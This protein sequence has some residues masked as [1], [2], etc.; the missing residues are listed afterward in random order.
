[1]KAK[2]IEKR[3]VTLSL[4]VAMMSATIPMNAKAYYM[5]NDEEERY[6]NSED[7]IDNFLDLSEVDYYKFD[8]PK[9]DLKSVTASYMGTVKIDGVETGINTKNVTHSYVYDNMERIIEK[10]WKFATSSSKVVY[11]GQPGYNPLD[12]VWTETVKNRKFTYDTVGRLVR[13]DFI[14]TGSSENRSKIY[15]LGAYDYIYNEKN[16]IVEEKRFTHDT[17]D[18]VD[19][20]HTLKKFYSYDNSGKLVNT[21]KENNSEIVTFSYDEAGHK[22]QE[23]EHIDNGQSK[24]TMSYIDIYDANGFITQ[25]IREDATSGKNGYFRSES[26]I[27]QFTRDSH[28]NV[29]KIEVTYQSGSFSKLEYV[30]ECIN[31]Y[32]EMG[33]LIQRT[34]WKSTYSKTSG[35][36]PNKLVNVESYTYW[37]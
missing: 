19:R 16:Q 11:E 1:M 24:S 6:Y 37:N 10:E 15:S 26:K 7:F 22:T 32:D 23:I 35:Y 3:I 2:E 21:I 5:P 4:C 18:M 12:R 25:H 20:G 29:C 8:T 17:P 14:N 28:G 27:Y 34:N 13:Q 9:E 31:E 30:I 36:S 33:R